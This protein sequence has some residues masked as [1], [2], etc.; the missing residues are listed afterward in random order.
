MKKRVAVLGATG[1]I[2]KSSLDVISRNTENFEIV[3][4]C[5]YSNSQALDLLKNK[6]PRAAC[7]LCKDDKNML[8][9]AIKNIQPDITING[10]SG[11]AGLEPSLAAIESGS[12]LA[13]ANKETI[14]MAGSFILN[15]A[16]E[17]KVNIIPVDSEH[18]AV[19][20]L[21][22]AHS[23][24][25]INEI[26]LT[27][28]GGPF[29]KLKPEE[30]KNVTAK[31]ALVHPTWNMG[32]KITIDSA[33]MAN[34]GLE[35]IEACC[36]FNL[37]PDKIK[38]AIHPQSVVHSMIRLSNGVIYAQLSKPDMRHPI[39]DALYWPETAPLN[40]DLL[41]FDFLTL[42]FEKPDVNKFPMLPLAVLAANNGGLYPCAYNAANET[43]AVLFLEQKIKF[44]DIPRITERVLEADWA[45]NNPDLITIL[46]A[47][48]KARAMAKKAA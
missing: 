33:S 38:V 48:A 32:Q 36:L 42:E 2:G 26:I 4:L 46:E 27:A 29:R 31:D 14:V 34:K 11:S 40:P 1:S 20:H 12:T 25:V 16:K 10:I 13:L 6:Y 28:S 23:N 24:D 5:A 35:I 7:V 45:A 47:D 15:K 21:L 43:A 9:E 8:T 3:L 18:S 22:K 19:F 30:M 39:A 17:K 41:N 37:P 44:T